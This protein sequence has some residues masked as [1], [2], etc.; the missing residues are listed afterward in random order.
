MKWICFTKFKKLLITI[1]QSF[2]FFR[3]SNL[4]VKNLFFI[5]CLCSLLFA[6]LNCRAN[7]VNRTIGYK[8]YPNS[9]QSQRIAVLEEPILSV[10]KVT[11][12][13]APDIKEEYK[14]IL[15]QAILVSVINSGQ[16]SEVRWKKENEILP[17][18][19][20]TLKIL[21]T[22]SEEMRVGN[23]TYYPELFFLYLPVGGNN[24]KGEKIFW[25]TYLPGFWPASGYFPLLAKSGTVTATIECNIE[26]LSKDPISI[27][28][29]KS[30]DYSLIL[31]GVYRTEL[32]EEKSILAIERT[33]E[34]FSLKL[35]DISLEEKKIPPKRRTK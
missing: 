34:D 4:I 26:Q 25:P 35:A 7:L 28:V 21:F 15:K 20:L 6:F 23:Y 24:E 17:E 13:D 1:F 14:K 10:P 11:V 18:N 12:E 30:E 19:T 22:A 5:F 32:A 31:Y 29:N 2:S 3:F 9:Y 8:V 33:L 27:K 16:F